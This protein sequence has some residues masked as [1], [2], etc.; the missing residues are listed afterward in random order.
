MHSSIKNYYIPSK[1]KDR[2]LSIMIKPNQTYSLIKFLCL[3]LYTYWSNNFFLKML[4]TFS[5]GGWI[6]IFGAWKLVPG[7]GEELDCDWGDCD[8]S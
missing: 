8:D 7:C 5:V 6:D 1:Q 3:T 2:L 4:P